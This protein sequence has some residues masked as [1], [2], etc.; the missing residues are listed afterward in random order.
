LADAPQ[1]SAVWWR[2]N[3]RLETNSIY[4]FGFHLSPR[5]LLLTFLS[6]AV[7]AVV[8]VPIPVLIYK[9]GV[10][11]VFALAGFMISSKRVKMTPLE[12]VVLYRL[13]G[14]GARTKAAAVASPFKPEQETAAE[15]EDVEMLP[16]E[17]F[18]DPTPYTVAGRLRVGRPTK[19]T[20]FLDSRQ[21]AECL[22]TPSS[23]QYW[24]LYK[25]ETK[26][27]GTHDFIIRAEGMAEPVFQ[28]SIAVF[29]QGKETLLEQV[30]K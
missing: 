11:G 20:A 25:P 21:L 30:K 23:S 22:V 1:D 13:T 18:T 26:D 3:S 12:L 24:F 17:D 9:A 5:T 6:L 16:V 7:G 14:Y 15:K 2:I 10:I 27:I 4:L 28:K 29:P 19:L 8:T